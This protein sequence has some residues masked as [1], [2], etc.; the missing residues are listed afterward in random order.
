MDL[1]VER[2]ALFPVGH[3]AE[4]AGGRLQG[5]GDRLETAGQ[6]AVFPGLVDGVEHGQQPG[7]RAD[8]GL[9]A[10]GDPVPV[11]PLAVIGV[12][13]LQSLQVGGPLRQLSL[14]IRG[15]LAI[16]GPVLG[17]DGGRGRLRPAA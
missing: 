5:I 17:L 2:V 15:P 1:R 12:L 10:D 11:D 9:L 14:E 3:Q 7:Q 16:L 4:P 6:L 8:Y 13:G